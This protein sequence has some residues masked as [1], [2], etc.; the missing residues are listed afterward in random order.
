M[1]KNEVLLWQTQPI[2]MNFLKQY[3]QGLTLFLVFLIVGV[4]NYQNYGVSVDEMWQNQMGVVSYNY[5]FKGD[6]ALHTYW[7]RD[8][9]VGFELPLV[10]IEKKLGL[11]DY[12]DIYLLRHIAS[13]IFFLICML[14]GYFLIYRLFKNQLVAC[15]GFIMLVLNPRLYS[16]SF[17]NSKDMPSLAALV[18]VL[19]AAYLAFENRKVIHYILM[20][21]ACGYALSI[22]LT[23]LMVLIPL[24]LFIVFDIFTNLNNKKIVIKSI[25]G[26]I[27]FFTATCLALYIS[28]PILWEH[29]VDSLV[30]SFE[31]MSKFRWEGEALVDGVLYNGNNLPWSY[32]PAWFFATIPE[33]W[34]FFGFAG[35]VFLL[36]AFVKEPFSYFKAGI[37]RNLMLYLYCFV[38]PVGAVVYLESVLYDDWRHLYFIYPPFV[39]LACY[40]LNELL[41]TK[42]TYA[43]KTLWLLQTIYL[44]YFIAKYHPHEYVYFNHLTSHKKDNLMK[45]YELDYWGLSNKQGLEWILTNTADDTIYVNDHFPVYLNHMLLTEDKRK[46]FVVTKDEYKVE[47]HLENYRMYPL[48]YP[49]ETAVYQINVS[50]S[51]ILRITK[52]R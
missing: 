6:T 9:G 18:L 37:D 34:L 29:P 31:S 20:G 4:S 39:I 1:L 36:A 17:F 41:K 45:K 21:V 16:H 52:L 43:H 28:W 3:W 7:E 23:N 44:V 42:L 48:K 49:E 5:V 22:R 33:V 24:V 25:T 30:E 11:T 32:I 26:F 40:G 46:R 35:I 8:H 13:H 47:Y 38:A 15:A 51:P 2:Y 10:I 14:S 12:R 27:L 19:Y 50:N